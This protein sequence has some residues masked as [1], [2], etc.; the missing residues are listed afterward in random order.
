MLFRSVVRR[1]LEVS[2]LKNEALFT[3][4][5]FSDRT[6]ICDNTCVPR[7][8]LKSVMLMAEHLV[9]SVE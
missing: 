9:V 8:N 3:Q 6:L 4:G 1:N 2:R 7:V 5:E